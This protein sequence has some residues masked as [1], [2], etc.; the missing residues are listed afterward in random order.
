MLEH[1]DQVVIIGVTK[2]KILPRDE[3][4]RHEGVKI[5]G[6]VGLHMIVEIRRIQ[7]RLAEPLRTSRG[8]IKK[9]DERCPPADQKHYIVSAQVAAGGYIKKFNLLTTDTGIGIVTEALRIACIAGAG[10]NVS[11]GFQ[12][13][14]V[15]D[16]IAGSGQA[17]T[18]LG[19]GIAGTAAC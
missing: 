19:A 4:L 2:I 16:G 12:P 18:I 11:I 14:T 1:H 3:I 17:V 15:I 8:I 6:T 10:R 9:S 13:K 7:R 5:R